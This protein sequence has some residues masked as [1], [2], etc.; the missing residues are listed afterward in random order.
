MS[1]MVQNFIR[2][3]ERC[4]IDRNVE[5]IDELT[6]EN[7]ISSF[8]WKRCTH[9]KLMKFFFQPEN[10]RTDVLYG[11]AIPIDERDILVELFQTLCGCG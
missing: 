7:H 6:R 11:Y 2:V 9:F 3:T 5:T 8:R 1:Q 4:K 10:H